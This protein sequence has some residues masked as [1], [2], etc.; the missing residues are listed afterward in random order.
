MDAAVHLVRR[1]EQSMGKKPEQV[2]P[3]DV[4]AL[5]FGEYRMRATEME[6]AEC[7]AAALVERGHHAGHLV[8]DGAQYEARPGVVV[9]A[10]VEHGRL[11]GEQQGGAR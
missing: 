6:A 4:L 1:A 8:V 2:T 7:L 11:T 5:V 10:R 3:A 9:A